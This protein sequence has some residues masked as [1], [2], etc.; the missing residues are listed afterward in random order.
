[1]RIT[2]KALKPEKIRKPPETIGEHIRERRL[3]LGLFQRQA[4]EAL[5]V[6]LFTLINWEKGYTEPPVGAYPAIVAFLGYDPFPK[7][8]GFADRLR[9]KRRELGWSIRKA[10]KALDVDPTALSNWERGGTVLYRKHRRQ[11]ASF[12]GIDEGA[13]DAQMARA[14]TAA[15]CKKAAYSL[16]SS[17]EREPSR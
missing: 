13:L 2:L 11:L 17:T 4:A 10:A 1:V 8:E 15:H 6:N 9:A 14:W 16:E 3:T 12:L 7:P 5:G